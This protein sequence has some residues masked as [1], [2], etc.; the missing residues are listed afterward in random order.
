MEMAKL[1]YPLGEQSFKEIRE[2][3]K[4]YVDKTA[5]I[6]LLLENKFYF[7]SRPRRFG[8]SLLL[9]TLEA[10]FLGRRDLF[11]GLAVDTFEWNW[12][13]HPVIRIDLNG[14]DYTQGNDALSVRIEST[15]AAYEAKFGI[16]QTCTL[17]A[18]R[19]RNLITEA[20]S[21]FGHKVVVLVDEYEKP[22]LDTLENETLNRQY[23]ESLRG[24]YSV[25]KSVDEHL[26]L[27]FLTG[28]TR[29]G[30]INIFSALN[31]LLDI[32]LDPRFSAICGITEEEIKGVLHQGV[33]TLAQRHDIS[34]DE[35]IQKLKDYYDG[36]HF[37]SDLTD[38][39]NP[40]SLL[41]TLSTGM[42]ED[43]WMQTGNSYY[44]LSQLRK[45]GFDFF[46][47]EGAVA[48][49]STLRGMDP[50]YLDPITLLYQSGY[51]T[52]KG[53]GQRENTYIL[54]L[55]NHEV[56]TALYSTVIPFCLGTKGKLKPKDYDKIA[57][58]L[59]N[60]EIE[61]FFN[62]LKQFFSKLSYDFKLLPLSDRL[63]QESDFQFVIFSIL[64]L[65]CGLENVEVEETTSNGRMD[66]TVST[67]RYLYIIELKMGEDAGKALGQI[68]EK[69]YAS[70]WAA[71]RRH[72][73]K[74]GVAFS[75]ESRTI[76]DFVTESSDFPP[77]NSRVTNG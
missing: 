22:L 37:S 39:Y 68:N 67:N 24:I 11:K 18:E 31:N 53:L 9:S 10:F 19:F 36:Y 55:P 6:P 1:I 42:I 58:W 8:K 20:A 45:C 13:E 41:T 40:Y 70:R 64:S 76:S 4:V 7:L 3:G 57:S 73:V 46:E 5:Y 33:N 48:D 30:Q 77:F 23:R 38:I 56:A 43:I 44:L 32:S 17:P 51:L 75:P 21:K 29:F 72:I 15:L 35:A 54:G 61:N 2:A 28:V 14:I 62:W 63:Q 34:Y 27:V 65:A 25:L 50:D 49:S 12:E 52:I 71:D 26:R 66:I 60:G 16:S 74:V 69:D 59:N 47:L